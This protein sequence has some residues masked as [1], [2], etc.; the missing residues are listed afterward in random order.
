MIQ[1]QRLKG[2]HS[3]QDHTHSRFLHYKKF[4]TFQQI[5]WTWALWKLYTC[6]FQGN[7]FSLHR[8]FKISDLSLHAP[9]VEHSHWFLY[10][11][12][13]GYHSL[14]L[15]RTFFSTWIDSSCPISVCI[16]SMYH[17]CI[18]VQ[19]Y[20]KAISIQFDVLVFS[21]P[22]QSAQILSEGKKKEK[23]ESI[24]GRKLKRSPPAPWI[25]NH[26]NFLCHGGSNA[27]LLP[28][29]SFG[30]LFNVQSTINSTF[31]C[32]SFLSCL[33]W[34]FPLSSIH[35]AQADILKSLVKHIPNTTEIREKR[36][37][38]WLIVML[39]FI[40]RWKTLK[41]SSYLYLIP[42]TYKCLL[43]KPILFQGK[44]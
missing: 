18:H 41:A 6:G 23:W 36:K 13:I 31:F 9:Q 2:F 5:P 24:F 4:K 26:E 11:Y 42:L 14:I 35:E 8:Y 20:N 1:F 17:R 28:V 25:L 22:G 3:Q 40:K 29:L 10:V 34:Q 43:L 16:I 12:S 44:W 39:T 21:E 32:K 7:E 37:K 27:R 19:K 33:F 30:L 15:Y 38:W